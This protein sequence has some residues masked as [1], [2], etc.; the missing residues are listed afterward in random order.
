MVGC[1][2]RR[3]AY[4]LHIDSFGTRGYVSFPIGSYE[5]R[6]P[7]LS[8]K[9]VRPLDAYGGLVWLQNQTFVRPDSIGLHGWSNGAMAALWAMSSKMPKRLRVTPEHA[10]RAALAF[11]PGCSRVLR[12]E[13]DYNTYARF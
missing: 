4:R 12:E 10:F 7:D 13:Y 8:E 9:E 11:Y 2:I 1:W 3:V 6:P 5:N